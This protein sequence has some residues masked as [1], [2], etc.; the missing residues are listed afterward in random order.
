MTPTVQSHDTLKEVPTRACEVMLG[1]QDIPYPVLPPG[2]H[3]ITL[4]TG[5]GASVGVAVDVAVEVGIVAVG[6]LVETGMTGI[7]LIVVDDVVF[8]C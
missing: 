6:V 4:S 1:C 2:V 7:T 8:P 3:G 5:G